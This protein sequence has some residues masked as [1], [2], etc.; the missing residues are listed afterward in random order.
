MLSAFTLN[1]K[2]GWCVHFT[3][4]IQNSWVGNRKVQHRTWGSAALATQLSQG[5]EAASLLSAW[6][7]H[8]KVFLSVPVC[9]SQELTL[10]PGKPRLLLYTSCGCTAG[11]AGLAWG[12]HP[13]TLQW[14]C[15][16]GGT[17]WLNTPSPR[18]WPNGWAIS[19]F[20]TAFSLIPIL[21]IS[22]VFSWAKIL[23]S[24]CNLWPRSTL[25]EPMGCSR[26]RHTVCSAMAAAANVN[27]A[28]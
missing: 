11:F 6:K 10:L 20:A 18:A 17:V 2:W 7:W 25:Q 28:T 14:Q 5:T 9:W 15:T 8:V 24:H 23:N 22:F 13:D 1:W 26:C 4:T 3:I 16:H 21:Q 12:E 19:S 27:G